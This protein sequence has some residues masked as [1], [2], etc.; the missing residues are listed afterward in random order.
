MGRRIRSVLPE[1]GSRTLFNLPRAPEEIVLTPRDSSPPDI[2]S[3]GI[4]A[5][6]E[7]IAVIPPQFAKLANIWCTFDIFKIF[8]GF[9]AHL[10]RAALC[11]IN[12][13]ALLFMETSFTV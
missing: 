2:Y 9:T 6:S 10:D 8:I 1:K 11:I 13:Q 5:C 7:N 3:D 12:S 4:T